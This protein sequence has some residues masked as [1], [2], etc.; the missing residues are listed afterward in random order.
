MAHDFSQGFTGGSPRQGEGS[1]IDIGKP[2]ENEYASFYAGYVGLVAETDLLAALE[3]QVG[4]LRTWAS[5][6][7]R[8]KERHRYAEGKW[9]VREILG[10]IGDGERVFGYRAL[11][12]ARGDETPLPSFDEKAYVE[13]ARF[14]DE[15]LSQLVSDWAVFRE[16][17][18][19]TFRGL[20]LDSWKRVGTASGKEVSVRALG[21]ILVGHVRHH[22]NVLRDKY[23][24]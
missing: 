5:S 2:A 16:G 9:S 20:D 13:G 6:V 12:I 19:A 23:G 14:D 7:P 10:H 24:V 11:C 21:A 18:L 17:N 4:E 15:R 3:R 8:D 1:T 22:M